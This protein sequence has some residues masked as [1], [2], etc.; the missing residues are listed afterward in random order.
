MTIRTSTLLRR[1]ERLVP[2]YEG[3]SAAKKRQ[4]LLDLAKRR[5]ADAET[6]L[7]FHESLCF[8]RAYPDDRETLEVVERLL[9]GFRRRGDLR[10]H[11]ENLVD[12]GIAGTPIEYSFY[13]ATARWLARRWAGNLSI[14]WA[15]F[16]GADTFE[17]LLPLLTTHSETP[18]LDEMGYAAREWVARLKAPG[19][20]DAAFLIRLYERISAD[21][22]WQ[23]RLF[24]SLETP[25]RISPGPDTPSRTLA[26]YPIKPF[27]FQKRTLSRV[28]P[29]LAKAVGRPPERVRPFPPGEGGKTI[30]LAREAMVTRSRD[31]DVFAN[32]DRRDVRLVDCGGGLQFACNGVLPERRLLLESV[33]GFLTLKNGVPIG[34]VLASA[35]FNSSE[36]A[37]N[38]FETFRGAE[39][40]YVYGR[41]LSMIHHLFGSDSFS[42]DP[43]QLG[44]ENE[45]GLASGAWWFYYKF[46]FRPQDPQVRRVAREELRRMKAD[47]RHRSSRATL[48][49]LVVAPL[50]WHL[51]NERTDV[52]GRFPLSKIGLRISDYLARRFGGKRK[53]GLTTCST[54]AA[55]LLGLRSMR[56]FSSGE[57]LAWRRW[58]P[59]ILILPGVAEWSG[60]ERRDLVRVVRAKGGR[61]E[62]DFVAKFDRHRK[63][64]RA[65]ITLAKRRSS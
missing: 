34:Y 40:G 55:E 58:S 18:A 1:L 41:V 26:R 16:E 44:H 62:S 46:G 61:R 49:R 43:Y 6:L 30:D 52:L 28:R 3:G 10:R 15:E 21:D 14:N 63:L 25:I 38:V 17:Q 59:L 27:H 36:I 9:A 65:L 19:E 53:D 12:T 37:Y 13:W 24:E 60:Q 50:F 54:E 7:R 42:I 56:G 57:R 2:V 32:A 5:F 20:S 11:R 39:A 31:L 48:K 64:R 29:D 45:E 35:L 33:Y 22:F 23:E 4:L 51:R 8:L 47:P